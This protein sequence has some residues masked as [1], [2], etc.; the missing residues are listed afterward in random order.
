M[1]Y[2]LEMNIQQTLKEHTDIRDKTDISDAYCT[3]LKNRFGIHYKKTGYYQNLK[4]YWKQYLK[5]TN[6]KW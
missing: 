1:N 3:L 6:K 2:N 5:E 4:N